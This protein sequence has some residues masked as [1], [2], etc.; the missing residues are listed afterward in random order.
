MEKL[1]SR[2]DFLKVAGLGVTA[3]VIAACAPAP[4]ATPVPPTAAPKAAPT[5]APATKAPEA[6]PASGG[7]PAAPSFPV[8]I[9][10]SFPM[11]GSEKTFGE[12]SKNGGMMVVD[13]F[14]A[15]GWKIE[16][17]V[18]DSKCE[19]Q[20][21]ANAANKLVSQDKVKY[22]VGEVCSK[23]SMAIAQIANQNKVLQISPTSTN[24]QVTVNEDGSVKPYTF[25]ACF[26]DPFQGEVMAAL[27]MELGAKK[28]AVLYDVGND[29]VKGLAEYFKS[30]FEKKGGA[31]PVFEAYN[32]D[33]ADF[34]AVLGKVAAANVEVM[35]LPDYYTKVNQIAEQ[36]KQKGIKAKLLGGDGWDS[37]ELKLDL[38]EGGFFSNHYSPDD[39]RPLVQDFVKA[40][41][42][43]YNVVP[44]A[45]ATLAYDATRVLLQSIS[46]AGKD[47]AT[48]AK[49]KMEAIKYEGISGD[50]LFDKNHNPIKKAAI[51]KIAG[52]KASFYKF[53]AP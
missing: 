24:P 37:P 2:R 15:A 26:L 20:E 44:D 4:T 8:K 43:K 48:A 36:V 31:V 33:D 19:A 17:V 25:R 18:A 42:A 13:A 39:P 38:L 29:Y 50:I 16:V 7:I 30:A 41:K 22:I 49:D 46:E 6:K 45:L 11:S 27:A 52:G 34:S 9:A 3:A 1:L 28:A 10:F 14:N 40:Y 47:D 21:A 53:V 32:K 35:F 51:I 12:S 23:A 5:T